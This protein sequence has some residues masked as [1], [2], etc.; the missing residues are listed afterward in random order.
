MKNLKYLWVDLVCPD[1]EE[2]RVSEAEQE[3]L[4]KSIMKI[5]TPQKFVLRL[6]LVTEKMAFALWEQLP[7]KLVYGDG[8]DEGSDDL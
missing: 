6:P 1:F 3:V 2:L 7:C 8:P 5:T 4:M